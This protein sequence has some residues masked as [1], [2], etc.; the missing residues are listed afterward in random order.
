MSRSHRELSL[1]RKATLPDRLRVADL[2]SRR[3]ARSRTH[4]LH[5]RLSETRHRTAALQKAAQ[6]VPMPPIN[7]VLT[8][9]VCAAAFLAGMI[10]MTCAQQI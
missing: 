7:P 4:R 3:S 9:L 8:F 10:L 5:P 1:R 6:G 2:Q